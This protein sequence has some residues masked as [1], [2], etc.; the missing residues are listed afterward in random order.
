M[1]RSFNVRNRSKADSASPQHPARQRRAEQ[2][3]ATKPGAAW[4][5]GERLVALLREHPGHRLDIV[6]DAFD[7]V[8]VFTVVVVLLLELVSTAVGLPFD[9]W[10]ELLFGR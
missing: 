9:A 3:L 8:F 2:R 10:L 1:P 6:V 4:V 5:D 7:G